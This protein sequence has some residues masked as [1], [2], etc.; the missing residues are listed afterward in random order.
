MTYILELGTRL[1]R[2]CEGTAENGRLVV[3]HVAREP[4]A[5]DASI[6]RTGSIDRRSMGAAFAALDRLVNRA[7]AG[8]GA[9]LVAFAPQ[10]LGGA[11]NGA[12]FARDAKRQFGIDVSLLS[13]GD[14]ARLAH[15]GICH[16]RPAPHERIR[17]VGVGDASIDF[18]VGTA[19]LCELAESVP[20][21]MARLQRAF[22]EVGSGLLPADSGALFSVARL[23]AGPACRRLREVGD[24]PLVVGSENAV[25][26]RHVARR[27][28]Y[29]DDGSAGLERV[30]L[31]ALVPEVL[32]MSAEALRDLGVD[33]DRAPLIGTTAVVVD[34][35]S[36]LL[37]ARQVRFAAGGAIEGALLVVTASLGWNA[38]DV[39]PAGADSRKGHGPHTF[40]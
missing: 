22:G 20:L 15:R 27:M 13:P 26:L 25:A 29:L 35:L 8:R 36:D 10:A 5:L 33:R 1:F 2:L 28:G 34:A 3:Q 4:V 24:H 7:R 23:S 6:D 12:R 17:L 40:A 37:G 9:H 14:S 31:H 39:R 16:G 18:S 11:A 38:A 32:A 21:G 19:A 30:A